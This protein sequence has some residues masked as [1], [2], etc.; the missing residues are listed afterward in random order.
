MFVKTNDPKLLRDT[1][2]NAIINNDTEG[3]K[4]FL[5]NRDLSKTL[6]QLQKQID[7]LTKQVDVLNRKIDRLEQKNG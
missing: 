5:K 7:L 1:N 2:S 3:Y 4:Q 6:L